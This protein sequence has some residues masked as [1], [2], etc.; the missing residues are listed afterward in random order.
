MLIKMYY[1]L[2]CCKNVCLSYFIRQ[3]KVET[4]IAHISKQYVSKIKD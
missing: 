2:D 4:F 3:L 1:L